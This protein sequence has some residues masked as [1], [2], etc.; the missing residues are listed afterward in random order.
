MF[1]PIKYLPL[2]LILL[3]TTTNVLAMNTKRTLETK[4]TYQIHHENNTIDIFNKNS[5]QK[6]NTI[7]ANKNKTIESIKITGKI[8]HVSYKGTSSLSFSIDL[9]NI[10]SAQKIKDK[11]IQHQDIAQVFTPEF[12]S[13]FYFVYKNNEIDLFDTHLGKKINTIQANKN[14]TIISAKLLCELLFVGYQDGSTD[15]FDVYLNKKTDQGFGFSNNLFVYPPQNIQTK[16]K[17]ICPVCNEKATKRCGRCQNIYYC[18]K[19][20]QVNHWKKHKKTCTKKT[21]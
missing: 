18:S 10:D 7:Q 14:K 5:S 16:P 15:T 13:A 1:K 12:Q 20:C 2:F 8:L 19:E 21:E 9:F 4:Y 11:A 3:H 17:K 6:I